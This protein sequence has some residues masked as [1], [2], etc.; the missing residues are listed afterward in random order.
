MSDLERV[1]EELE[2]YADD[3]WPPVVKRSTPLLIAVARA[4]AE[5]VK[6]HDQNREQPCECII[7]KPLRALERKP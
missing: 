3:V 5:W 1:L 7:C 2:E 6:N 4:S